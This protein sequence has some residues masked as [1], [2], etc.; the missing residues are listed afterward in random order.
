MSIYPQIF[1]IFKRDLPWL[2][3]H[4]TYLFQNLLFSPSQSLAIYPLPLLS[5][6]TNT[7]MNE[8]TTKNN[9]VRLRLNLLPYILFSPLTNG[10]SL[11][12]MN[13]PQIIAAQQVR[14]KWEIKSENTNWQQIEK[15]LAEF[16]GKCTKHIY[17]HHSHLIL[18][19]RMATLSSCDICVIISIR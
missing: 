11:I 15:I 18:I 1:L 6:M 10:L 7:H 8:C 12:W 5:E 14:Q 19:I 9:K 4:Q 17:L 2:A 16:E 13:T 3:I